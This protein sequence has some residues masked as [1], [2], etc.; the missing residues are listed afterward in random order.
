MNP[1]NRLPLQSLRA[2]EA[3]ARLGSLAA[4]AADLG[5]TPGAI[6]QQVIRAE[7]ILGLTLFERR[8]S[9]M[10]PTARGAPVTAQLQRGFAELS[11][12]VARAART[13]DA[14]TVSVAPVFAARWLIWRLPRFRARHPDTR[15]RL[16]ASLGLIDP[17]SGEADICIRNGPGGYSGVTV[18]KLWPQVIFPVCAPGL[19][20][21]LTTHADL[22]RVPVIRETGPNFG[23]QHWLGP[24]GHPDVTPGDGPLFSDSMLCLDAA[25][26]GEGVFLSFETLAA[27]A[28][29]MG[30]LVA[31]FPG[32][33]ATQNHYWLVTAADARP[34]RPMRAFTTWLK[35]E[36]A[37]AGLGRTSPLRP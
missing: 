30:R 35:E 6:S 18:E 26:S 19:A 27:D 17:T 11:A 22:A 4:A 37:A 32:R 29:A 10:V 36:V 31:P 21:R 15:I 25:I 3:V 33:H 13:D 34:T 5:V 9:G 12:A 24:E 8:P 1:L 23:W 16:D 28:I 7:K 2:V 14:L 20:T